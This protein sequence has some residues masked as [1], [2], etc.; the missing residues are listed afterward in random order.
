[1][2]V[3][4]LPEPP[5]ATPL[6]PISP[7]LVELGYIISR[8]F[9]FLLELLQEKSELSNMVP[10]GLPVHPIVPKMAPAVPLIPQHPPKIIV[11]PLAPAVPLIPQHPPKIIVNPL[12]PVKNETEAEKAERIHRAFEKM[13]TLVNIASQVEDYVATK[14]KTVVKKVSGMVSSEETVGAR[15]GTSCHH[16]HRH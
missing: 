12:A 14:M 7:N 6:T 5:L 4:D 8:I 1:M 16:H 9:P 10:R 11:N 13:L 15:A 3:P 2:M